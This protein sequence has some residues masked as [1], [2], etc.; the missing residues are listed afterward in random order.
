[1][2]FDESLGGGEDYLYLN[3]ALK[4]V[5][6]VKS[7][8]ECLYNHKFDQKNS[9]MNNLNF[10]LLNQQVVATE[11]VKALYDIE[12]LKKNKRA[13]HKRENWCKGELVLYTFNLFDNNTTKI[14]SNSL[15]SNKGFLMFDYGDRVSVKVSKVERYTASLSHPDFSAVQQ[16]IDR[17]AEREDSKSVKVKY[18]GNDGFFIFVVSILPAKSVRASTPS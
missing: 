2:R 17:F 8:N 12:T 11:K 16:C 4:K 14:N 5:E 13:F 1:M 18:T 7:V 9:I 15:F 10:N 6:K 3:Q